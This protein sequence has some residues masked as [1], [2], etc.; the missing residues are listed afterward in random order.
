MASSRSPHILRLAAIAIIG[1]L[2]FRHAGDGWPVIAHELTAFVVKMSI[3]LLALSAHE[4]AHG[5][6]AWR[7]GDTTARDAGRLTL[8]PMAHFSV[9]GLVVV[10][11]VLALLGSPVALGWAKPVPVDFSRTGHPRR[12]MAIIAAAGP[13]CSIGIALVGS[14]LLG[15]TGID[16]TEGL[17]ASVVWTFVVVNLVLG[18]FNMLP[19]YPMDGGR[20][21]ATCLPGPVFAWLREHEPQAALASVGLIVL[22][23]WVSHALGYQLPGL[24]EAERVLMQT[25]AMLTRSP[26]AAWFG[27]L[28]AWLGGIG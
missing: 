2:V 26:D 21:M 13:I 6:A 24:A 3:A 15:L 12:D 22:L 4:W 14:L 20:I 10:P 18:I 17:L 9:A 23:P 11:G 7:L 25:I 19:L 28:Q 8:N 5:Y 16:G 1:V 27:P